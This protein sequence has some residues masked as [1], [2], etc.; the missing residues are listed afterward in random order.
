MNNDSAIITCSHTGTGNMRV[1]LEGQLII[2]NSDIIK[3]ELTSALNSS[4]NLEL[5]FRNVTKIDL[6]VLQLLIALQKSAARD[7]KELL[8]GSDLTDNIKSVL[9]SSGL[10]KIFIPE[11]KSHLNGIH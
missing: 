4:Q 10:Q 7:H 9:L 5:A 6:P 8:L 3:K 11:S 1:L 2:R